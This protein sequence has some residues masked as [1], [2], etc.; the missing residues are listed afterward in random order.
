MSMVGGKEKLFGML[1]NQIDKFSVNKTTG[2]YNKTRADGGKFFV[3]VIAG[4]MQ[5]NA[6]DRCR[7]F[8]DKTA[9]G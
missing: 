4:C 6:L 5:Y 8:A 3:G 9:G 7:C 2:Y 1:N